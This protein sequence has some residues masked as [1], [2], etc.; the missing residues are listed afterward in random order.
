MSTQLTQAHN[1]KPVEGKVEKLNTYSEYWIYKEQIDAQI[2][3]LNNLDSE[4]KSKDWQ[5][6]KSLLNLLASLKE[7]CSGCDGVVI[8]SGEE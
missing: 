4:E 2:D 1:L 7:S 5:T 6:Y 8:E 3:W